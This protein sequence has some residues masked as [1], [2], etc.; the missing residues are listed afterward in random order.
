MKYY[1]AAE[2]E[3]RKTNLA[4]LELIALFEELAGNVKAYDREFID[5]DFDD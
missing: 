4:L 2:L 1:S 3:E 5:P